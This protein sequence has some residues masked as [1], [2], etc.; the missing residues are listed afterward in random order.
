MSKFALIEIDA[1]KGEVKFY[2]L[3]KGS[4]CE[5]EE[6]EDEARKNYDKEMN[7]IYHRMDLL[8][9][10]EKLPEKQF[11]VLKG[12]L[13]NITECEIKTRNLRVYYFIDRMEG[14]VVVTGGCKKSQKKDIGHFRNIVVE[15]L[16]SKG[17]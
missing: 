6:F 10:K 1:V 11:R 13:K 16:E 8:S 7:T 2:K 5:F 4:V 17:E 9:R 15:Y 14:N 3:V 12:G